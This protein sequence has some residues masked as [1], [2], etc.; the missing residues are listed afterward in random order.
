[1]RLLD[2]Y[3]LR[4]LLVPLGYC[5]GGFLILWIALNLFGE[6]DELQ[7]HKM[8]VLDI[9]EYYLVKSPEFLIFVLPVGLLL[10]LLYSLTN[11]A[12]Y[13]EITAI[14]A[15]GLSLWR[16]CLPYLC[17]G[18]MASLLL[19]VLNELWAPDSAERAEKI[20]NRRTQRQ[21]DPATRRRETNLDFSNSRE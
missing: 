10:A 6:L 5:L 2:R 16:T 1:M 7:Q 9:L 11:H 14:R 13:N 18:F 20:L 21:I 15:A 17:V 3:L 19:F 4:E 8:S 12:R